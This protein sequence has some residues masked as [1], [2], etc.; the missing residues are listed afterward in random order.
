[1]RFCN[2][3]YSVNILVH[4]LVSY[5]ESGFVTPFVLNRGHCKEANGKLQATVSLPQGKEPLFPIKWYAL[6]T[7]K[8]VCEA[9][10]N[11]EIPCPV[12]EN[13]PRFFGPPQ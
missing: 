6:W 4:V 12:P 2:I 8:Q 5:R 7:Q 3:S 9:I 11:I 10:E 1:M 13:K